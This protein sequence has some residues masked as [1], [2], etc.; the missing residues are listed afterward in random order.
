LTEETLILR[1]GCQCGAVRYA[2][3][4]RSNDAYYCHCRMCQK[5]F[6]N[7]FGTFFAVDPRN[8]RWE[9]GKPAY[10]QSSGIARRGFCRECG[11]PL[12]FEYLN[13]DRKMDL[14]V[15]SLDEPGRMRPVS[16]FGAESIVESFFTDDGLPCSRTEDSEE[17]MEKWRAAH[18]P[19]STPGPLSDPAS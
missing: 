4:A 3:G 6:G 9:R 13:S 15:G 16:H 19:D 11:T 2:V 5:A 12:T 14:T 8:V 17:L 10:F 1:G 18:G 7:L